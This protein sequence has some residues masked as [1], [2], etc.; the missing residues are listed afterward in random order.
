MVCE[1]GM[2]DEMGPL[3]F[4]KKE[5]QIFLGREIAQHRDYSE[6]TAV[7]I[8]EAVRDMVVTAKDKAV[9]L[10][11][12]N[13]D[14]L[15]AV[16]SALLEKETIMLDDI[17]EIIQKFRSASEAAPA[18]ETTPSAAEPVAENNTQTTA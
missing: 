2:S 13:I 5:E 6:S 7:R 16:A 11:T 8:D 4:G 17:E 9:K 1:W 15:K 12:D 3:S 18:D 10:L 14:I